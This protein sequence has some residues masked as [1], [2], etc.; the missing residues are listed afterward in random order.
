MIIM[1]SFA[2]FYFIFSSFL[3]KK[4]KEY[5]YIYSLNGADIKESNYGDGEMSNEHAI[6]VV[7][8]ALLIFCVFV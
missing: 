5:I 8:Y 3:I 1:I 6:R 4:K 7:P 2:L